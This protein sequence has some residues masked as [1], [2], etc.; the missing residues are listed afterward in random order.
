MEKKQYVG[1][2]DVTGL[3]AMLDRNQDELVDV[4]ITKHPQIQ[5]MKG[6]KHQIVAKVPAYNVEAQ[7]VQARGRIVWN[8]AYLFQPHGPTFLDPAPDPPNPY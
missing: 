4:L 5:E 3:D 8:K 2:K 7:P 6:A 1:T